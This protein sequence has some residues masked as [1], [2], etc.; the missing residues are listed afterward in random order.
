MGKDYSMEQ[1]EV[2][3]EWEALDDVDPS[4]L[5]FKIIIVGIVKCDKQVCQN[6]PV[7]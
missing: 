3:L 4:K 7:P 1:Y 5:S 6:E 2:R